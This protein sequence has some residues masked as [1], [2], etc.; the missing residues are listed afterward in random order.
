MLND[1]D[2]LLLDFISESSLGASLLQVL[3]SAP[4]LRVQSQL[5]TL[6][7]GGAAPVGELIRSIKRRGPNLVFLV[8]SQSLLKKSHSL[9]Q[10]LKETQVSPIIVL[11]EAGDPGD[12]FA[13]LKLGV[14]D[15][16]TPPVSAYNILPRVWWLIEQ[17][18]RGRTLVR[19]LKE[20]FGLNQ[21]IGESESFRAVVKKIPLIAGCNTSVLISGETGTGKE[22]CARA[23]HYLSP[24]AHKPFVP[25]NCG[26]IPTELVENELF[27][28]KRGA[29][30]GATMAQTGL[31]QEADGGSLFLD[32]VDS[33]P[34]ASQ[35]KL[36]RFLQDKE[37]RPLGSAK[38][39][40][41]DVRTIAASNTDLEEAVKTGK[42]RQD[43]YYRLNIIPLS[44]PPLRERRQDIPQLA[45]HFLASYAADFSKPAI[46]FS[47]ESLQRLLAHDWPGN[48]R[49]LENVV[50]RAIA[51]TEREVIEPDDLDLPRARKTAGQ[52]SFREAKV[53]F[54]RVYI[55]DLLLAHSGN[56]SR[57]AR[58]AHKDRRAFWELIRKHHIDVNS[59]RAGSIVK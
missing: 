55:E 13:L 47:E 36:L 10:T 54:E 44:L 45:S 16:I 28:H 53:E 58:A 3:E 38:A 32:E 2:I 40:T 27:G 4:D 9:F 25:I 23:I 37:Y 30:T 51:L 5:A 17:S 39:L 46:A 18:R 33:L 43:L 42:M 12:I 15:F 57:A 29:F 35:V 20:K 49:E 48:V 24:R 31:I 41:S 22:L 14:A 26:A 7:G 21:L 52:T 59:F 1:A 19:T 8:L 34:L 11:S 6:S 50:A 56:I